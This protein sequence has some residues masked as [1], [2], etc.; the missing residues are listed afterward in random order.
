MI[1]RL[2][3]HLC[4]YLPT[5]RCVSRFHQR[6]LLLL[7]VFPDSHGHTAAPAFFLENGIN[8]VSTSDR[9][10]TAIAAPAYGPN[11]RE[12][13]RPR[14]RCGRG[15]WNSVVISVC[16]DRG[17]GLV[18]CGRGEHTRPQKT[19]GGSSQSPSGTAGVKLAAPTPP[20]ARAGARRF[21]R[22]RFS[23]FACARLRNLR[24]H[25]AAWHAMA[26]S[27]MHVLARGQFAYV[28]SPVACAP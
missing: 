21:A 14:T 7:S 16:R 5:P 22:A 26:S 18:A 27:C 9:M 28:R 11:R 2:S 24:I 17:G 3:I 8:P 6:P 12:D 23:C 20:R 4:A 10:Y 1:H 15:P 25:A 13:A 19:K